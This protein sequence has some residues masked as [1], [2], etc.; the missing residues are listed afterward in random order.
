MSIPTFYRVGGCVRDEIINRIWSRDLPAD[1]DVDYAVEAESYDAMKAEIVGR[2]GDIKVEKP[3]FLTIKAKVPA[4]FIQTN[5][6]DTEMVCDFVMCRSDGAYTDGR[7]P[8]EVTPGTLDED[9]ERRDFRMNAIAI[10]ENKA[11]IDPHDGWT[12]IENRVIC[13]V[14]STSK[15]IEE[16]ALRLLRAFRFSVT[17]GFHLS[18]QLQS[19]LNNHTEF[20][21]REMF[22]NVSLERIHQELTKCFKHNTHGTLLQLADH[23]A[24]SAFL[25]H[26]SPDDRMP[27]HHMWLAPTTKRR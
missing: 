22:R 9:L 12:D 6:T 15:R 14:G 7:H 27:G 16:D 20:E 4:D 3:E 8:D 2:G 17:L 25:F 26:Q 24:F 23:E 1:A 18:L 11:I 21:Y 13:C 19:L 10:N 5:P